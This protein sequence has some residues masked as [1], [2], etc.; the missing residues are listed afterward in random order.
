MKKWL[1]SVGVLSTVLNLSSCTQEVSQV[2]PPAAVPVASV[3]AAPQ[4]D[5]K[6]ES[7]PQ[8]PEQDYF[9]DAVEK[10]KRASE[11]SKG[12]FSNDDWALVARSWQQ[13]V[14]LLK[15]VPKSNANYAQAQIKLKTYNLA[16]ASA[17][18]KANRA[19]NLVAVRPTPSPSPSP[20]TPVVQAQPV[21]RPQ[22]APKPKPKPLSV[23][24]FV[25]RIYFDEIINYG[26][27]GEGLWCTTSESFQS[28]LFA[29]RNYRTLNVRLAPNGSSGSVTARINSSNKGGQ[30]IITDW[31]FVVKKGQTV[32]ER[33]YRELKSPVSANAYRKM[34]GGWCLS[35]LFEN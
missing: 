22:A 5:V 1:L 7:E 4:A 18:S 6:T 15:Q 32:G 17:K 3:S 29:P 24:Q 33:N 21:R 31:V 13:T 9:K 34:V 20:A 30:P 19:T 16:L 12:A 28:A 25:E 11:M 27:S 26:G 10:A 23:Q 14:D 2:P 35:L 8:Q